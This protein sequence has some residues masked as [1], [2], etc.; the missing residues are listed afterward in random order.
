MS[1]GAPCRFGLDPGRS[2]P[3]IRALDTDVGFHQAKFLGPVAE[4]AS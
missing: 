2:E 3:Q 4:L 1:G